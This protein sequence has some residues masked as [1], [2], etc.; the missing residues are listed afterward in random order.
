MTA[1]VLWA[2]RGMVPQSCLQC[3]TG[4]DDAARRRAEWGC[5]ADTSAEQLVVPCWTCVGGV[6]DC[7]TCSGEGQVPVHRCPNRFVTADTEAACRGA[8]LMESGLLPGSGGWLDQSATMLDAMT[9]AGAALRH[10]R[11]VN[12]ERARREAERR[13]RM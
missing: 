3:A 2:P 6:A 13:N 11:D 12:A 5:D 8:V 4:T 9:V 7:R 1:A 10:W